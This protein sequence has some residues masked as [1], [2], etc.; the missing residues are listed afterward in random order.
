[1]TLQQL[2]PRLRK[3]EL[4]KLLTKSCRH[5]H[6]YI[7]HLSCFVQEIDVPE[8]IGHLDIETTSLV[9]DFGFI[10]TYCIKVDG[11]ETIYSGSI[12]R[13]EINGAKAGDED[14]EVVRKLLAD[15]SKFDRLT[16]FYSKRFDI[17]F[18]RTRAIS[19]GLPFPEWGTIK[20]TDVYDLVKKKFKLTS[21]R[22]ENVCRVLLGKTDKTRV[23]GKYWRAAARGDS[24]SLEYIMDHNIR[25]VVD[26]EK[27]YRKVLVHSKP[28]GGSI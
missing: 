9:A 23:D 1:M 2:V 16:G 7:D 25:D 18:I 15:M 13:D 28:Q 6:A 4:Q 27:V 11:E 14:K 24:K 19:M 5:R 22:L 21:S 10:L 12:T 17:P 20:H 3:A 8:R 26:L